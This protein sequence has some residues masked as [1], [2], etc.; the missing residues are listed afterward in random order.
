MR[1]D[2]S[3]A[4]SHF[5]TAV[6]FVKGFPPLPGYR[7]IPRN[8]PSR[9][10]SHAPKISWAVF[11]KVI[12]VSKV[13]STAFLK[14]IECD[15]RDTCGIYIQIV[16]QCRVTIRYLAPGEFLS[17]LQIAKDFGTWDAKPIRLVLLARLSSMRW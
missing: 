13:L 17:W 9:W 16:C 7:I 14:A 6:L 4:C 1:R 5:R 12:E 3:D 8:Q 11:H 2:F 10:G 15:L